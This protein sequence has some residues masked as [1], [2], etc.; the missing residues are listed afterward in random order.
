MKGVRRRHKRPR[1]NVSVSVDDALLA[2]PDFKSVDPTDL[3][4]GDHIV[5]TCADSA[6]TPRKRVYAVVK[7]L[8]YMQ[9]G[10]VDV[11]VKSYITDTTNFRLSKPEWQLN[12][13]DA[14]KSYRLYKRQATSSRKR[15][16]RPCFADRTGT[17]HR[18]DCPFQHDLPP[19]PPGVC[20]RWYDM[21]QC[22]NANCHYRHSN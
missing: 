10:R 17:C 8:A 16:N 14:K 21:G 3:K 12:L 18:A 19:V 15:V 13:Q 7:N 11:V 4:S 20:V 22:H 1:S 5:Y 6:T 9:S 2:D